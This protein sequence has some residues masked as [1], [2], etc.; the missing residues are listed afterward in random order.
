MSAEMKRSVLSDMYLFLT[1][2][3][4]ILLA[5]S[6]AKIEEDSEDDNNDH[7]NDDGHDEDDDKVHDA[8]GKYLLR[9]IETALR[10]PNLI[11]HV[12]SVRAW[13]MCIMS[14]HY[15]TENI[16]RCSH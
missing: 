16:Y 7:D 14:C 3:I 5:S 12:T 2:K 11:S 6:P 13:E 4:W 15:E 1:L 10:V 9:D 8:P